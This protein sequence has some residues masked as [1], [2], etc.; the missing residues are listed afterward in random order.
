[1][2]LI[3]EASLG[4]FF[5]V[6]FLTNQE[7]YLSRI[8]EMDRCFRDSQIPCRWISGLENPYGS[9]IFNYLPPLPYYFGALVFSITQSLTVAVKI[10][11]LSGLV[12]GFITTYLL[13]NK[14]LGILK[15]NL[16]AIFY[17]FLSLSIIFY[18]YEKVGFAWGL[19]FF[20]L[21]ILSL[22][23]LLQKKRLQNFLFFSISLSLLILST[24]AALPF[25]GLII[26]WILFKSIRIKDF[27]FVVASL[28]SI[29]LAF[30][31]SS[32]YIFPSI[33]ER[34]LVYSV[35]TNDSFRYLPKSAAEKPQKIIDS[36]Y[37]ILAG[38]S[39]IFNFKQGTNWLSFE[40]DTK[41]HTIIRLSQLYFPQWKLFIDGKETQVEYKNNS[42]G[43]MTIIL[44][45]G[46]HNIEGRLIDT[47]IRSIS[48]AVT[49]VSVILTCVL[50][51][52][53]LKVVRYWLKYYRKRVN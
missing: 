13:I 18:S 51:V 26:V 8:Y 33:L 12:G 43:L 48:N 40:T 35:S 37:Q 16:S 1:V 46:K 52:I 17:I 3:I 21:V 41:T 36:K 31:L 32:F 49:V 19:I 42:L 38:D 14:L 47:H 22:N 44:G 15:A 5:Y 11:L 53:Q 30:L 39:D 6:L 50:W 27:T 25:I 28:S 9:P 2:G 20:P 29:L 24:E 7:P 4:Y 10:V 34:N 23:L 45:E